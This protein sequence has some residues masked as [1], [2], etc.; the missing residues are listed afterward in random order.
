MPHAMP[1]YRRQVQRNLLLDDNAGT[2]AAATVRRHSIARYTATVKRKVKK[3]LIYL[4][5]NSVVGHDRT[6]A[7]GR[8]GREQQRGNPARDNPS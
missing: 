1:V 7:G 4:L 8:R 3:A 6:G 2:V 5:R